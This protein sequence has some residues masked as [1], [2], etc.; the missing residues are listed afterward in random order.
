MPHLILNVGQLCTHFSEEETEA[1]VGQGTGW[2]G[3]ALGLFPVKAHAP[4][5]FPRGPN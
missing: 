1:Q 3:E 2:T 5:A 4:L